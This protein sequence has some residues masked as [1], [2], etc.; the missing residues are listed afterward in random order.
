VGVTLSKNQH[1]YC[2]KLLASADSD[3]SHKVLLHDWAEI[4]EPVDRIVVIEALEH[5]G[6]E[7]FDD[8]FTFAY[9]LMPDD[10]VMMVHSITAL[11]APQMTDRSIPITFSF[12]RFIKFVMTEI[13]PGGRLPSIEKVEEHATKAGFTVTLVQSLQTDFAKTL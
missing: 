5:F 3:R 11:T 4:K 13:F 12:A 6:F 8:F 2:R 9:D 7:R 10:G 1:E